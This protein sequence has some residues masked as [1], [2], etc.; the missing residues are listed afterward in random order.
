[1][2]LFR[3]ILFSVL[4]LCAG[5]VL[6]QMEYSTQ[7][8][9]AIKYFEE[10]LRFYNAKRSQEAIDIL[11]K[12]I[13][14]DENFI[15]AH[16]VSGDCYADMGDLKS[17]ISQYQKA[18]DI[19]SDFFINSYKQ[20]ADAQFRTGDYASALSNYKA[21]MTKKRVNPKIKEV[22][23]RYMKN[24]EF[25]VV[26]KENVIPFEPIN[27]G[28][29]VNSDQ[30]EYFPVLTADEQTL[31]F[32]RNERRSA[33]MDYQED[34]YVSV[35]DGDH[36][37]TALSVGP[38]INTDDNEGAQTITADG[39][40]LF[41]I[42]CN[43]KGG[44]GSCDIYRSLR[45]GKDWGRPENLRSPVNSS[46]WETQ[47]SISSDGKTL[48]FVSN[49]EGG[50]GGSDIWVT[51]LAP[52]NEWSVPRNLGDVI[53]TPFAEETPFIH[54]DG[55]TLYFTSNGHVGMGEKD[56]Y[57]TTLGDDGNWSEP[58][59]LGYPINTWNDEQ[60]L[61]VAASG[62]NAYFSSDREGGF[63]KLDLYS[64]KLYEEAR[65]T[66]VTYVKGKVTD[67]VTGKPLG[68][69]FELIDLETS[70]VVVVSSSDNVNGK[71]LVTLPV[72]HDYALNVS[73]DD[74]LFYSE[75]FS[76]PK[77]QDISKP[78]RLDVP[79]QPIKFG[80]KVVL[81]NIF[82]ETASYE[83]LPESTVELDKLVAFMSNNPSIHIEIGGHTDDVG[84]ASDNQLLSENRA[85][86]VRAYLIT[87]A[88][89]ADRIQYKGYGEEQ[90]V[91]TNETPE[92]R[93]NNRRTEFKVLS[94]E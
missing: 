57:M 34:F 73:K 68:A 89:S 29:A 28:E 35:K 56:I 17:A 92:G 42:G 3:F 14:A 60:G 9:K 71:F 55:R 72:D 61:F 59:N 36:W 69:K 76:L 31:I 26:A 58:K 37:S 70:Q 23:E 77:E 32:T 39:Q 74:Y 94:G 54:P 48:Y 7:S 11:E 82:F 10:A 46:K 21:F 19:N 64:F 90:P 51:H 24:A 16:M 27:L 83:L 47:P 20:L 22:A 43:R 65:P 4:F 2:K 30:Y 8:K 40:Q 18:V 25:G 84:E 41:F 79:L 66:R 15:E 80:E 86:S 75:H 85:K 1:M 38:P 91:D 50:F 49:R 81:K 6:A 63:G 5:Q 13:K 93:A 67:K 88:I 33:G 52:N 87:N 62:E 12:A 45:N 53:N 44:M 78:Y